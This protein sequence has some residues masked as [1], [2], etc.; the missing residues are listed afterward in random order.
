M[1]SQL[2]ALGH[3]LINNPLTYHPSATAWNVG[4][5]HDPVRKCMLL[6]G[7]HYPVRTESVAGFE[8]VESQAGLESVQGFEG[9]ERFERVVGVVVTSWSDQ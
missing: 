7:R 1:I 2:D 4:G 3:C 6:R 5:R 8:S 9:V